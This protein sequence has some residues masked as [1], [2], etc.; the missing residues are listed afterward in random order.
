M[1]NTAKS[2][3]FTVPEFDNAKASLVE[4]MKKR[5]NVNIKNDTLPLL[6]VKPKAKK[7]PNETVTP[8]WLV[9][10]LCAYVTYSFYIY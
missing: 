3:F 9:A 8:T 10:E 4:Y 1:K 6:L 2:A 7:L 5:Y